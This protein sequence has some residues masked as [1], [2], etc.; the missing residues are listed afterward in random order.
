MLLPCSAICTSRDGLTPTRQ[1]SSSSSLLLLCPPTSSCGRERPVDC[2]R[3]PWCCCRFCCD[4]GRGWEGELTSGRVKSGVV[5]VATAAATTAGDCGPA[6]PP[7]LWVRLW[8]RIRPTVGGT[9]PPRGVV[10]V[11]A[12]PAPAVAAVLVLLVRAAD[13]AVDTISSSSISL[14]CAWPCSSCHRRWRTTRR[15]PVTVCGDVS[16]AAAAA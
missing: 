15:V 14:E 4:C 1:S 5:A 9:L 8:S 10:V 3:S 12:P 16:A 13:V 7:P 6:P 11:V 2:E